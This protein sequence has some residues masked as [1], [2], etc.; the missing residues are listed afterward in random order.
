VSSET[1]LS[2]EKVTVNISSPGIENHSSGLIRIKNW[3]KEERTK[4]AMKIGGILFGIGIV[5][6]LIPLAHF[7]L[8]PAFIIASPIVAW[9]FFGQ[10]SAVLGGTGTCPNCKKDIKIAQTKN[11]FPINDICAHCY[12]ALVISRSNS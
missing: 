5:S 2:I 4:R 10:T 7:V 6:V 8:V 3:S 11:V 1:D 12:R 9:I